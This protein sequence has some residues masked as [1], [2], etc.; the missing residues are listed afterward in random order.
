[1]AGILEGVKVVDMGHVVAVPAAGAL[2]SDW[3]AEVI[4]LEPLTGDL[5]RGHRRNYGVDLVAQFADGEVH[6]SIELLNRNKKGLALDLKQE[7]GREILYRLVK[8]ADVFMSNYEQSA[9]KKLKVD[10]ATLSQHNPRLIY[11]LLTGYG[12][13]GPDK[14]ERGFDY[15]A[16]WAR[17]GIQYMIGEPGSAPPPQRGGM[18]DRVASIQIVAGISAALFH[19]EKTGEGQAMEFSLYHTG[20]WVL[21]SDIQCALMGSP[22]P[23]HDRTRAPNPLWNTYQ[24]KEGRWIW[25]SMLQSDLQWP[26]LCR[27]IGRPE[28]EDDPRFNSMDM[29]EQN[30]EELISILDEIFATKATAE[31][32]KPLREH[33]CIY[34]RVQSP[35]EVTTDPQSLA[36]DFFAEIEHPIGG[37]M[38]LVNTP[39]KFLQNPSS[40]RAAAPQ[41]GQHTEE[42]LVDLG[43]S[44]EDIIRLKEQGVIL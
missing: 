6:S 2:L 3:G 10:Y 37:K 1:M 12:T 25:L 30:C 19:R 29:R 31:W 44:W 21:A 39:A 4:K 35:L 13:T 17:T 5:L 23:K 36:N 9:L 14:D 7:S 43:Y 22:L 11:A 34:A 32:E 18:M 27:A 20:V 38:R 33:S 16:A 15:S 40:V 41:I 42:I 26:G 8:E 28:L 24:T